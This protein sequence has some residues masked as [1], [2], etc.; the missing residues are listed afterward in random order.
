MRKEPG[1]C[2]FAG[3][4]A[5]PTSISKV[6]VENMQGQIDRLENLV[7]S[8]LSKKNSDGDL[9]VSR[10]IIPSQSGTSA[11]IHAH[12]SPALTTDI[13]DPDKIKNGQGMLKVDDDHSVYV[14]PSH[15]SDVLHEVCLL[16]CT[17]VSY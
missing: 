5:R 2:I 17:A 6:H 10:G 9:G 12:P 1:A 13:A 7:T 3:P 11:G 15:W 14:G 8:L 4:D 16:S